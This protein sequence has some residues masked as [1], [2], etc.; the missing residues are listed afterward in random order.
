MGASASS[1]AANANDAS[2]PATMANGASAIVADAVTEQ[3]DL[4][5]DGYS[6]LKAI[7][8]TGQCATSRPFVA[9]GHEWYPNGS[10]GDG[11]TEIV[12]CLRRAA[13]NGEAAVVAKVQMVV[14]DGVGSPALFATSE[15]T[16][17]TEKG[18]GR[19]RFWWRRGALEEQ[20]AGYATPPPANDR[21]VI[22]F[23]VTVFSRCRAEHRATPP[24]PPSKKFPIN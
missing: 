6:H 17:F 11:A 24:P 7:L 5:I 15:T 23:F 19:R 8:P 1:P 20:S 12:F 22:R 4:T 14:L 13:N 3:H 16:R 21:F 10:N 2:A 18:V 9:G